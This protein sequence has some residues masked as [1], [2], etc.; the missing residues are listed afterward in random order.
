MVMIQRGVSRARRR[1]ILTASVA[2]AA[3]LCSFLIFA[4]NPEQDDVNN[5]P[6]ATRWPNNSFTWSLN[7]KTGTNVRC[8]RR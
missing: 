5:V 2:L 3:A 7:P 1:L 4:Y 8:P 6:V